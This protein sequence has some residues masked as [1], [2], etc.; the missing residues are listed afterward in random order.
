MIQH[1]SNLNDDQ[2]SRQDETNGRVARLSSNL[3]PTC[4]QHRGKQ[5]EGAIVQ[6]GIDSTRND[7]MPLAFTACRSD[8][9]SDTTKTCTPKKL[10]EADIGG[11]VGRHDRQQI[12]FVDV[13]RHNDVGSGDSGKGSHSGT[14]PKIEYS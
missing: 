2:P 10:S 13:H 7:E 6:G 5:L 4:R 3:S 8:G 12:G 11:E 14:G 9:R 1:H